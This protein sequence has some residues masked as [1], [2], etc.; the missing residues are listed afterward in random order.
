[1]TQSPQFGLGIVFDEITE[2]HITPEVFLYHGRDSCGLFGLADRRHMS[3]DHG[4]ECQLR[5]GVFAHGKAY[6]QICGIA[7][8]NGCGRLNL[9]HR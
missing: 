6:E 3:C 7:G 1:M 4:E 9:R 2:V 8:L 5:H